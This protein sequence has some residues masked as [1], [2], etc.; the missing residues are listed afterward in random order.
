MKFEYIYGGDPR[1]VWSKFY[2]RYCSKDLLGHFSFN[3][4]NVNT[5]NIIPIEIKSS[6]KTFEE[7]ANFSIVNALKG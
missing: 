1:I 6:L 7:I 3:I 2:E 4:N 5:L